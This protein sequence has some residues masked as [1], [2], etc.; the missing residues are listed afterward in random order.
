ML[1]QFKKIHY[2]FSI[3]LIYIIKIKNNTYKICQLS[4]YCEFTNTIEHFILLADYIT[5]SKKS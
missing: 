3:T 2:W 1:I 5:G 4:L